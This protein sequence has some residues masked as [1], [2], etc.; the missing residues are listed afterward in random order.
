MWELRGSNLKKPL[1][2]FSGFF[3]WKVFWILLQIASPGAAAGS[4]GAES[5]T[6]H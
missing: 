2:F 6:A 4:K 3:M 5:E 1:N